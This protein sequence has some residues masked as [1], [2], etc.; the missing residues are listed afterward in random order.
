MYVRELRGKTAA[1]RQAAC[2][3]GQLRVFHGWRPNL[4]T[5]LYL[6]LWDTTERAPHGIL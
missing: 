1:G 5:A 6:D 2:L 4:V 3:E